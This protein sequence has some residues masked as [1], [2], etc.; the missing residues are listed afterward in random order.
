MFLA[1]DRA[2]ELVAGR[3][4]SVSGSLPVGSTRLSY[5]RLRE[6]GGVP[7]AEL[8]DDRTFR[9]IDPGSLLL[10]GDRLHVAGQPT[11]GASRATTEMS[12]T[13][14]P[15]RL[16]TRLVIFDLAGGKLE[17][18]YD[19]PTRMTQV[20]L[21]GTQRDRLFLN[22][23]GDGILVV[24]TAVPSAPKALRF[25]RTLGWASHLELF[26]DD[27]YVANGHFGVTHLG[28]TDPASFPTE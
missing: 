26:D 28:L 24:D 1:Q 12:S 14:A 15:E 17:T 13:P 6:D 18:V 20:Q 9:D 27:L 23:P 7:A 11:E 22:L 19:Q 5:L 21:M 2:W 4:G 10:G 16:S 8:L 25:V 3:D